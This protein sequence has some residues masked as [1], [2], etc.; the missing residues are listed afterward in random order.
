MDKLNEYRKMSDTELTKVKKDALIQAI[1]NLDIP[2][3]TEGNS[4]V[5]EQLRVIREGQDQISN[6]LKR[7]SDDYNLLKTEKDSLKS[8]VDTL[9]E[10]VK[11]QDTVLKRQQSYL[12]KL[13]MKERGKNLVIT[14]VPE[15]TFLDVNDDPEKVA[16]ILTLIDASATAI[17]S[18]RIGQQ[19]DD[20]VRPIL[21][22]VMTTDVRNKIVSDAKNEANPSLAGIRI[23][24]D[25]H[26]AVRQEW[27][28]LFAVKERLENEGQ[29]ITIDMRKRQVLQDGE[30]IDMWNASLF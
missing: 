26:P 2:E 28:R 15:G 12:E 13:D 3:S 1:R 4:M 11:Q 23:K 17:S 5:M 16:K 14:G 20:K 18:R 29:N 22:T 21:V 10:K 25:T 6:Q 24:K 30:V 27:Q 7:L 8:E 9:R 19:D